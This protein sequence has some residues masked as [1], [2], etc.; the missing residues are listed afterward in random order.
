MILKVYIRFLKI[1]YNLQVQLDK[2][3][4]SVDLKIHFGTNQNNQITK[5]LNLTIPAP[6]LNKLE[7]YLNLGTKADKFVSDPNF[8]DF[9]TKAFL[10]FL[11]VLYFDGND[12]TFETDIATGT[13]FI[14]VGSLSETDHYLITD[15]KETLFDRVL[16]TFPA[17]LPKLQFADIALDFKSKL[18]HSSTTAVGCA[19][20]LSSNQCLVCSFD[21]QFNPVDG[22]CNF[23]NDLYMPHGGFCLTAP[24]SS[25]ASF[26]HA[27]RVRKELSDTINEFCKFGSYNSGQVC[28]GGAT[29]WAKNV[30]CNQSVLTTD[31]SLIYFLRRHYYQFGITMYNLQDDFNFNIPSIVQMTYYHT[32]TS[33]Y[34]VLTDFIDSYSLPGDMLYTYVDSNT[35]PNANYTPTIFLGDMEPFIATNISNVFTVYRMTTKQYT[36]AQL[37]AELTAN[38]ATNGGLGHI[39]NIILAN[40]ILMILGPSVSQRY[41]PA[42]TM[43]GFFALS[44]D[45]MIFVDCPDR[46]ADCN[47]SMECTTCPSGYY[48]H[49]TGPQKECVKC[50]YKCQ[51]CNGAPESCLTANPTEIIVTAPLPQTTLINPPQP[52]SLDYTGKLISICFVFLKRRLYVINE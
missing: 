47:D 50:G 6:N 46:C 28:A 16:S 37:D 15:S 26:Q 32:L 4:Q 7:F 12:I 36:A 29:P 44:G 18:T 17:K 45:D 14:Y 39:N 1:S 30:L 20:Q 3:S 40:E 5:N 9:G 52:I 11:E 51:T 25:T 22:T 2:T 24:S 23:C 33:S 41:A 38:E 43:V 35:F 48:V 10:R 27:T 31:P 13:D 21:Y 19:A 8:E 42:S 34:R 49:G